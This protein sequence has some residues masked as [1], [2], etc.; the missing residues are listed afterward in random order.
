MIVIFVI[1]IILSPLVK[2]KDYLF[3]TAVVLEIMLAIVAFRIRRYSQ[4]WFFIIV[5]FSICAPFILA[6]NFSNLVPIG[7]SPLIFF[8]TSL[9]ILTLSTSKRSLK[10]HSDVLTLPDNFA[11]HAF[12]PSN[13][14]LGLKLE[15]HHIYKKKQQTT[16]ELYYENEQGAWLW[17]YESNGTINRDE[18]KLKTNKLQ[19]IVNGVPVI[20]LQE[21]PNSAKLRQNLPYIYIEA[22]WS[23]NEVNFNVRTDMISPAET[24]TIIE[25]MITEAN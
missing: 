16:L 23:H 17:I 8:A 1:F 22:T 19:K 6:A 15:D 25:S 9:V 11:F 14:I 2:V 10:N 12:F 4:L 24:E 3:W 18:V 21:I 13:L 20:I 7:I 5:I